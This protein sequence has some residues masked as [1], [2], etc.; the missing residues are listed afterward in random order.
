MLVLEINMLL[1][2][3]VISD[4]PALCTNNQ[5]DTA[6][7]TDRN[8][9]QCPGVFRDNRENVMGSQNLVLVFPVLL[10]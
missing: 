1:E 3:H 6:L 10:Q 9:R 7:D 4:S 2:N 8:G 5:K